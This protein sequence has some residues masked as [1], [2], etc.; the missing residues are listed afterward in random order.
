MLAPTAEFDHEI[1][2]LQGLATMTLW[3]KLQPD[4]RGIATTV[5]VEANREVVTFLRNKDPLQ[6]AYLIGKAAASQYAMLVRHF[7]PRLRGE[8]KASVSMR[9][10][11]GGG[12]WEK[13]LT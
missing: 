8:A 7:V 6:L 10:G 11:H 9:L 1:V 3:S 4:L 13:G 2:R 12:I 5:M